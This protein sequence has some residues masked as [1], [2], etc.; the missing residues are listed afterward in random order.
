MFV[1]A[2]DINIYMRKTPITIMIHSS[3][4]YILHKLPLILAY[5]TATT[6]DYPCDIQAETPV[7][8]FP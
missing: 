4:I 3:Y 2:K 1:T 7:N 8:H 5:Y 6:T